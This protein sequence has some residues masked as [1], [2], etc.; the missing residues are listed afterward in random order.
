MDL[1]AHYDFEK[2][3]NESVNLVVSEMEHQL[4]LKKNQHLCRCEDCILDMAAFALNSLLPLYRVSLMG[5]LYAENAKKTP[6][7]DDVKKAVADAILKV[8]ANPSHE[9]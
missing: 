7:M 2:L 1:K 3:V 9:M 8:K 4:A 6:Y 5:N